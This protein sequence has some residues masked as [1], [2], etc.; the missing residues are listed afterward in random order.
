MQSALLL[1]T[2]PCKSA[3][4]VAMKCNGRLWGS[5]SAAF[6][7]QR[8]VMNL[9]TGLVPK[10]S[11]TMQAPNSREKNCLRYLS[12]EMPSWKS[13]ISSLRTRSKWLQAILSFLV[14]LLWVNQWIA[15]YSGKH[16]LI[17]A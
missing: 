9:G 6:Q 2:K 3:Q 10:R 12:N 17:V 7:M 15:G 4:E 11:K 13:W 5:N 16:W 14:L 1:E 8:P